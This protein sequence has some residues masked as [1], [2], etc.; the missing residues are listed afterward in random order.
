VPLSDADIEKLAAK[1]VPMIASAV[2]HADGAVPASAPPIANS[3][4]G[5]PHNPNAGNKVWTGGYA[6]HAAVD[7][8]RFMRQE[9]ATGLAELKAAIGHIAPG[10]NASAIAQ[11]VANLLAKRLVS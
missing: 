7:S 2:W 3:D 8:S 9:L 10:A 11:E 6:V 1:L 5:D 4:F